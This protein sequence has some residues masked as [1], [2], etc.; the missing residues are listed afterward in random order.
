[1]IR[2]PWPAAAWLPLP[3]LLPPMVVFRARASRTPSPALSLIALPSTTLPRDDRMLT[4][5]PPF[6]WIVVCNG[7]AEP[8]IVVDDVPGPIAIPPIALA[9]GAVPW[10]FV[11]ITVWK[12][13]LSR[14]EP[15][16]AIP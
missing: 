2:L 7:D 12:T 16:I 9:R 13:L 5:G 4:P 8:P 1:M 11:P 15:A 6:A 3:V 14:A 10:A